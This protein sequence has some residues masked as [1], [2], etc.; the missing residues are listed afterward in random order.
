MVI[1][2]IYVV[3]A[4]LKYFGKVHADSRCFQSVESFDRNWKGI[5]WLMYMFIKVKQVSGGGWVRP[6]AWVRGARSQG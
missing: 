6:R 3:L 1:Y 2:N 5:A 4:Q